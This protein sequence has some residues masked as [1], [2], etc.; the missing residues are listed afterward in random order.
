LFRAN[1]CGVDQR[2]TADVRPRHHL[3]ISHITLLTR[4][5]RRCFP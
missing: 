1:P 3:D 4:P 5:A 2:C